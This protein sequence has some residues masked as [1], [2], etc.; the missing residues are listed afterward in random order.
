[1][2]EAPAENLSQ[3]LA[4]NA[5][6][7]SDRTALLFSDRK[8]SYKELR[9]M[10]ARLSQGLK[11]LGVRKKDRVAIFLYNCPEFIIGYFA[12]IN[13]EAV[14][15]PVNNMLKEEELGFIL[16]DSGAGVIMTSVM[17][18]DIINSARLKCPDLRHVIITDG[19]MPDTINFYEVI[20]RSPAR[21]EEA[22]ADPDD[23]ASILYTSGTTGDP[24]GAMLTHKN[25]LSNVK[26]CVAGIHASD[27][28]NFICVLPMFHSF[29]FTVCVILPLSA[30]ASVTIVEHLRPFR[31]VVRNVIKKKVTIFVGIPAIFNVLAH[32]Q[33]PHV[34][35][36]RVLK[37]IDPLRLCVSGA[38]AL[39]AEVLK[40]FE[41]KFKVPLLEGY[42]LTETSPVVSLNPMRGPR[43]PGSVGL[44]IEGVEVKVVDDKGKDLKQ[45]ETGELLVKGDN[46]MRGY[47]NNDSATREFIKDKWLYTGD[48]SRIDEDGYIYIVDRKKDMINV[49]GLNV[50]PAEIERILLRHPK[51]KEAAVVRVVDKLKGEVPKAVLVLK[52]NETLGTTD[53]VKYLREHLASFK[54]PKFVE[55]RPSLPRTATGKVLKRQLSEA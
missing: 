43:K 9:E 24:K 28:D 3:M 52:E 55:F 1:M 22:A 49:R 25:F 54:I 2:R 12:A 37:L 50:Y 39:P 41:D 27:K 16:K 46:V 20:E 8:M 40:A 35:T 21:K 29:A 33:I 38:A 36:S 14:C 31:R 5:E 26:S 30:G 47:F 4:R 13:I 45:G 48:I 19:L 11:N 18:L 23:T 10:S 44:P 15:V 6:R 53:V 17:Y 51:I 7:F 42:G 34:F 32:M